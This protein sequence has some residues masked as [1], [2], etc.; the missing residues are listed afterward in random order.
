VPYLWP[1]VQATSGTRLDAPSCHELVLI[2]NPPTV[3]VTQGTKNGESHCAA[4]T[5]EIT[6]KDVMEQIVCGKRVVLG[7]D[8]CRI[9]RTEHTFVPSVPSDQDHRKDAPTLLTLHRCESKIGAYVGE[10]FFTPT[11]LIL[12]EVDL[13]L[14]QLQA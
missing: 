9:E 3:G 14:T 2:L 8:Q 4:L 1:E 10:I 11:S 12:W 13:M 6:W 5:S 7:S